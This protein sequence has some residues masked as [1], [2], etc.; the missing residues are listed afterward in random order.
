MRKSL[1]DEGHSQLSVR[2]QAGLVLVNRNRLSPKASRASD[3]ELALCR[4]MDELHL[5]RPY[6]GSR[7]MSVELRARG[8][9]MS[10]GRAR[11][12]MRKMGSPA[13]FVEAP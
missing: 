7:R 12:L 4:A 5:Q 6:Y 8:H 9:A 10:R 1:I 2:R 11:R 13:P 3:E